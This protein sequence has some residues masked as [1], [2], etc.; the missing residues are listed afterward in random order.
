VKPSGSVNKDQPEAIFAAAGEFAVQAGAFSDFARAD[1]QA[2]RLARFGARVV[3]RD[4]NPPLW[5]VLAGARLTRDGAE[6]LAAQI[7]AAGSEAVV[8][9]DA[10]VK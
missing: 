9:L 1:A 6:G 8:V 5:R 3:K 7:R 2:A 10:G 4:A